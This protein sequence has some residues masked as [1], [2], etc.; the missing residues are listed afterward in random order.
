MLVLLVALL[1]M[2]GMAGNVIQANVFS[3]QMST[4][5]SLAEDKIEEMLNTLSASG[6]DII[7]V[8]N[9]DFTREW[10]VELNTPLNGLTQVTVTVTFLWREIEREVELQTIMR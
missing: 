7:T 6:N 9:H 1:G 8:G 5:T 10:V 3:R 4:A 2:A